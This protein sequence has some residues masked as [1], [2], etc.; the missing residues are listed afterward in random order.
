MAII[1]FPG[2]IGPSNVNQSPIQDQERT[3]NFILERSQSRAAS[4][5]VALYPSPGFQ[6]AGSVDQ[7]VGRASFAQGRCFV[8]IGTGFYELTLTGPDTLTATLRGTVALDELPATIATNGDGGNQVFVTSGGN[9]YIYNLLT[10]VFSQVAALNGIATMGAMLDSY[11][12]SL[13][14]NSSTFFISDLNDGLVFDPTQFAQRSIQPDPWVS[15]AVIYQ[16][17]WLFGTQTSEVWYDTGQS[18]FPF[19]P[20]QSGLVPFGIAAPFSV[21]VVSGALMWLA[22]TAQGGNMVV[23]AT[24]FTPEI[25]STF[26]LTYAFDHYERVDDAVGDTFQFEGHTLYL[27]TFPTARVTWCYDVTANAWTEFG[28]WN[29]ADNVYDPWR[30]LFHMFAFGKHW[31]LDRLSGKIW[32]SDSD[33]GLDVD[34]LPIR[35]LRRAP[36][37]QQDNK[38]LLLKDFELVGQMG[39]GTNT[40]DGTNPQVTLTCSTDGGRT[41]G[42]AI[43]ASIGRAGQYDIRAVWHRLPMA[44]KFVPELVTSAPVPIRWSYASID[45]NVAELDQPQPVA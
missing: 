40:G 36:A 18:P 24:G 27:L 3:V 41:F 33:L 9:G 21:K 2:F 14:A 22:Q 20:R 23:R 16:D 43:N 26:A 8:V 7:V 1:A 29:S 12:I 39:V 44:R 17:I 42:N 45:V 32:H 15:M 13:D 30:T 34:G 31:W 35:R 25:V 6:E 5:P 28:T 4:S 10:D 19:A 38:R 11:F 37:L